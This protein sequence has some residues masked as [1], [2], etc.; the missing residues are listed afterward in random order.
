ML[1]V[2]LSAVMLSAPGNPE[3]WLFDNKSVDLTPDAQG[4]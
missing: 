3:H 4:V 2:S 1:T